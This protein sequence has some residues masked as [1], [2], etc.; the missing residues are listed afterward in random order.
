MKHIEFLKKCLNHW[1]LL[2]RIS[3]IC[4]RISVVVSTLTSTLPILTP[5]DRLQRTKKK[6]SD[7]LICTGLYMH[8]VHAFPLKNK[9]SF[10]IFS[11]LNKK[12]QSFLVYYFKSLKLTGCSINIHKES[13][14]NRKFII[15]YT[16]RS[17][18]E[19]CTAMEV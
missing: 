1:T 9:K 4:G 10:K 17:S 3:I 8:I 16:Y 19:H 18:R 7:Y 14:M 6:S 2:G 12:F 5:V 11:A 13:L 15:K